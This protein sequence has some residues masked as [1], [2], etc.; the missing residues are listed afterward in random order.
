MTRK[1]KAN[2]TK[3]GYRDLNPLL[4]YLVFP[5][6]VVVVGGL[7]VA[8]ILHFTCGQEQQPSGYTAPT[9]DKGDSLGLNM[10]VEGAKNASGEWIYEFDL[11]NKSGS[12]AVVHSITLQ[13][14][15]VE[16][17]YPSYPTVGPAI[18]QAEY[19]VLLEHDRDGDYLITDTVYEYGIGDIDKFIVGVKSDELGW[20]YKFRF[21]I[22]WYD[23]EE[24]GERILYSD[25]Y[26]ARFNNG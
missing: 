10:R 11:F 2:D 20:S 6:I 9:V 14:L 26:I 16:T 5:L 4:K 23:P 12:I 19:H 1:S 7:I 25:T 24:K 17:L 15:E 3:R 8:C 13:V 21:R 22:D 18:M